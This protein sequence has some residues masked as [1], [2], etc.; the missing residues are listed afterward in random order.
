MLKT[1]YVGIDVSAERHDICL[2]SEDGQLLA[3]PFTIPNNL[4]GA[5]SLVER[6][7]QAARAYEQVLVGMEATGIYWFH[8]HRYLKSAPRLTDRQLR[9]MVFN[10]KLIHG[11][12]GACTAMDKT[13]PDDAFIIAERL[14]F[15]R[16]P[17]YSEPDRRYFPLQRLT[18]HRCQ[19]VR[20]LV[21]T[22]CYAL[23]LLF[24]AAS[25]YG[26]L[27]PFCD[28]FGAASMAVL[29]EYKS[30]DELACVPV[31][32]L[33]EFI[34]VHGRRRFDQPRKPA[35]VLKQVAADSFRLDEEA[36]EPVYFVLHG[37]LELVQFLKCQLSSLDR[38][39]AREMAGFP[40]TLQSVPGLGPVYAAGLVAEI[41]GVER[42][43]NDSALAKYA[44]LW[45]PRR[46]SGG[47]E[48]QDRSVSK[49]GNAYL[50][51]Y[52]CEAANSLREHNEEYRAYYQ[53]QVRGDAQAR[54]QAGHSPK[55]PEAG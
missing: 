33:A 45:W 21:S 48:A 49:A 29:T 31:E 26:R 28:V 35:E 54:P 19:L 34:D 6:L 22:K 30:L 32:Q 14:R 24:L 47:F 46:Q 18:R 37:A 8:L 4:P 42:F 38:R 41:A 23:D 13:D 53:R 52:L 15:G 10:P 1:L 11:F 7:D 2:L 44:G 16:L 3:K 9:V 12:R 51:Y 20:K 50:R 43:A 55:R 36:V 27:K 17:D 39:I 40:N 25:E 5:Q